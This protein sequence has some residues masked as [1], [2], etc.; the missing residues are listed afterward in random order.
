[1]TSVLT[2]ALELGDDS[3]RLAALT[4]CRR[5]PIPSLEDAIVVLVQHLNPAIRC[6]ALWALPSQALDFWHC[7]REDESPEVRAVAVERAV[8]DA[9]S[10]DELSSLSDLV[11]D[12]DWRVRAAVVRALE[13]V[14]A[15]ALETA[16]SW[17][18]SGEVPVRAGALR[19]FM[20][21]GQADRLAAE[22]MG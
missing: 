15:P 14:G 20:E 21:Q 6:A 4:W 1:L 5:M 8:G 2:S 10:L 12:E 11:Q 13:R 16:F 22:L 19:F 9:R 17:L 18:A 7:A 3:V